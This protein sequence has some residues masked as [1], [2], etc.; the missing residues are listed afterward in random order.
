[1]GRRF[2]DE[3]MLDVLDRL[4]R[5]GQSQ[6]SVARAYGVGKSAVAML[7]LRIWADTRRDWPDASGDGTL[8]PR[9]WTRA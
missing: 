7:S 1:M 4:D 9:W 8:P 5:L 3:E 2:T 6:S